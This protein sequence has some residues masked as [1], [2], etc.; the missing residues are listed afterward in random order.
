MQ[1]ELL[2]RSYTSI[3]AICILNKGTIEI[4]GVHVS[5]FDLLGIHQPAGWVLNTLK[6]RERKLLFQ[7]C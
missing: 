3:V 2:P 6:A 4:V 1:F 5:Q 7:F